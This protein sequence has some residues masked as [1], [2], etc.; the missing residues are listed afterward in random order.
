MRKLFYMGLEKI[1]A[2]YTHQLTQWNTEVF[3]QRGIDYEIVVG[4]DIS[5]GQ[6]NTGSVLDAHGRTHYS[7]TQNAA[8]VRKLSNGE[9]E[10]DDVIFYEDMY[11]PGIDALPYIFD[12]IPVSKR[13]R[14]FFRCLAQTIDPDD[15]VHRTGMFPWMRRYEQIADHIATKYGG[16]IL[17]ASEEMVPNLRICEF[18]API[19]VTGL[20]FGKAEV[21]RRMEPEPWAERANRVVFAARWDSEK[22]PEFFL[23]LAQ[24]YWSN[25]DPS[26]E[27]A[28]LT[29]HKEL[30]SNSH[31]LLNQLKRAIK[32]NTCNV[33]L[34]EGLSKNEYYAF[35][36]DSKVLFNC[37]LQ[38]WVSNT[39]SEADALGCFP[40]YPAYRSFPEVFANDPRHM[41][42]PWSQADAIRKIATIMQTRTAPKLGRVSDYQNGTIGRTLDVFEENDESSLCRQVSHSWYRDYSAIPK[43]EVE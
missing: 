16:G 28:I 36:A 14:V 43:Y 18:K 4:E 27:F 22:Q 6:I 1:E 30:K 7:L 40:I 19:Y 42:V 32:S 10:G 24:E 13:P 9:I 8:L 12:Q 33:K 35:L 29:G 31:A 34:Y 38:D 37:A 39:V 11:T 21:L 2:R 26:V 15:F 41:Y 25:H 5:N 20:P 3:D 23:D 17:A